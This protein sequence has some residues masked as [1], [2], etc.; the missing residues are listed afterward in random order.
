MSYAEAKKRADEAAA[1]AEEIRRTEL[2]AVVEQMKQQIALYGITPEDL[3][4]ETTRKGTGLG[5][6]RPVRYRG[7]NG[8]EWS[9]SGKTPLWIQR[10]G[11]NKEDFLV[12][13]EN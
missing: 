5:E 4:F 2:R 10:S 12:K 9:G 8:E 13:E 3:G 7:P 1:A 6:K 11:R